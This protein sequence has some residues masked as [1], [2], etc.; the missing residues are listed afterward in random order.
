MAVIKNCSYFILIRGL[1]GLLLFAVDTNSSSLNKMLTQ[2]LRNFGRS[3][4]INDLWI[5]FLGWLF[6]PLIYK[7]FCNGESGKLNVTV[8]F[9]NSLR[10]TFFL[11]FLILFDSSRSRWNKFEI[12]SHQYHPSLSVFLIHWIAK[13]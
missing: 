3:N 12:L 6:L 10:H 7:L 1:W 11:I 5:L 8:L 9:I 2:I 13:F 4:L